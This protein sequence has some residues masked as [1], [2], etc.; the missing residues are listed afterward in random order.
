MM[1]RNWIPMAA[2]RRQVALAL[3]LI[4]CS[5]DVVVAWACAVL[6]T[7][8]TLGLLPLWL[9]AVIAVVIYFVAFLSV[10]PLCG[11]RMMRWS[12][13]L[14]RW[15]APDTMYTPPQPVDH[16]AALLAPKPVRSVPAPR[17]Q[18]T[19]PRQL[20]KHELPLYLN[21]WRCG[22]PP[23]EG[24]HAWEDRGPF[25][26]LSNYALKCTNGHRWRH[27]TDGG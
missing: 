23:V 6:F 10:G 27:S 7:S 24:T 26:L 25:Q 19:E 3:S 13:R 12:A 15:G 22:G 16:V 21:C 20:T 4:M 11:W 1:R 8:I 9:T 14:R 17:S 5:L 18:S 2:V